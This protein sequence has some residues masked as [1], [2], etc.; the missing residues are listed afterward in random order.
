MQFLR[1]YIGDVLNK[2][3][4]VFSHFKKLKLSFSL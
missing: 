4:I 3:I 2:S 1:Y